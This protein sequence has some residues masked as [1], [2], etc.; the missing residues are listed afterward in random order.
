MHGASLA[1]IIGIMKI[2]TSQ[3][4]SLFL[5][6]FCALA[7]CP[8]A[9]AG[10]LLTSPS[11]DEP[12]PVV[13]QQQPA[14]EEQKKQEENPAAKD[15]DAKEKKS[16]K[17]KKQKDNKSVD[18]TAKSGDKSDDAKTSDVKKADSDAD[19]QKKADEAKQKKADKK[20]KSEDKAAA[21]KDDDTAADTTEKKEDTPATALDGTPKPKSTVPLPKRLASFTT[22]AVL[23]YPV[24][25]A[26][27]TVHQTKAG[28]RDFIG[29]STNP[30]KVGIATIV[31][32][33]F[34]FVGGMFEGAQYSVY[35]SWKGS[36]EEPFG[37]S[38]FSL[39]DD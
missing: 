27:R 30:I 36:G 11:E 22:G 25:M 29:D 19:K 32:F 14:P 38:T 34:G 5:S 4:T 18:A 28:N 21:E 10:G 17:K 35:N 15:A 39:S 37:K 7:I 16:A 2:T 13:E 3:L 33:P 20:K 6:L 23:G 12:P 24:A 1:L 31:S 26:K 8:Q 9:H